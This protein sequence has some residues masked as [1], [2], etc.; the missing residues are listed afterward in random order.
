MT[1]VTPANIVVVEDESIVAMDIQRRLEQMGHSVSGVYARGEDAV[2]EIG[3]HEVDL[4][5]M[6]IR[7]AGS[8]DGIETARRIHEIHDLPVLFLTAY[9]DDETLLRARDTGPAAYLVKP[10]QDREL[11]SMIEIAI[12]RHYLEHEIQAAN[13]SLNQRISELAALNQT[14]QTYVAQQLEVLEAYHGVLSSLRGLTQ[15]ANEHVQRAL[16]LNLPEM[17]TLPS[18]TVVDDSEN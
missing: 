3:Q 10:V 4:I 6:D 13:V 15:E 1:L 17:P 14:F 18:S 7:L 8:I 16:A 12:Y 9:A 5:L 2:E 11:R